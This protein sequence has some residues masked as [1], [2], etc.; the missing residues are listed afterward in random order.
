MLR[1]GGVE[2]FVSMFE[3]KTERM[4]NISIWNCKL[5]YGA[6]LFGFGLYPSMTP[7]LNVDAS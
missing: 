2:L 7:T 6:T 4:K 3:L 1:Y 5:T